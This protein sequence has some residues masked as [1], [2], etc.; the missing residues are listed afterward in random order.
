MA[1]MKVEKGELRIDVEELIN[2]LPPEEKAKIAKLIGADIHAW[3]Q[4]AEAIADPAG[5][6]NADECWWHGSDAML[7]VRAKLLPLAPENARR[8]AEKLQQQLDQEKADTRRHSNWAWAMYH[9]R[10][11]FDGARWPEL[12]DWAPAA[13]DEMRVRD[14]APGMKAALAKLEARILE[15]SKSTPW[16]GD[17]STTLDRVESLAVETSILREC[18]AALRAANGEG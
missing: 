17:V 4:M 14:A 13:R 11:G 16:S 6:F 2:S 18:V 5:F 3:A 8:V 15:A 12:P 7:E 1:T 9:A 10:S